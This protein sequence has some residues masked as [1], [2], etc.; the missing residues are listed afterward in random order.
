MEDFYLQSAIVAALTNLSL[1]FVVLLRDPGR[2]VNRAFSAV[3]A[4]CFLWTFGAV[5]GSV[6][7]ISLA[8]AWLPVTALHFIL[9]FVREKHRSSWFWLW[10]SY[11]VSAIL[12]LAVLRRWLAGRAFQIVLILYFAPLIVV[13]FSVLVRRLRQVRSRIERHQ[14]VYVLVGTIVAMLGGTTDLLASLG[15]EIPRLGNLSGLLYVIIMAVAIVRH[16]F[17]DMSVLVGRGIVLFILA[18]LFWSLL[19]VLGAWWSGS[20]YHSFF[21]I[22]VAT[23]LLVIFYEPVK[24]MIE[25]QADKVLQRESYE[26]QRELTAL[27]H[28][29]GRLLPLER[30]VAR[31]AEALY[32]SAKIERFAIYVARRAGDDYRLLKGRGVEGS[33]Y[34][35]IS[36]DRLF[37][38]YLAASKGVVERDA[39][40]RDLEIWAAHPAR[41][42]LIAVS[43]TLAWLKMDVVVPFIYE[44]E[45]YGFMTLAPRDQDGRFSQRERDLLFTVGNQLAIAV[46]N[47]RS[48]EQML[49]TD[50]LAA[51]GEMAA[52][53]A[54]EIRNPLGAIKAA[55]QMLQAGEAYRDDEFMGIIVEEVNRLNRVVSRFL[56][57]ARPLERTFELLDLNTIVSRT[58]ELLRQDLREHG[59]AVE[60]QLAP[61]NP[62]VKGNGDQL[63]Q[64][65]MNLIVNAQ[66][67]MPDGGRLLVTTA[68]IPAKGAREM[69][70]IRVKDSGIGIAREHMD[71]LFDPF[72]TSKPGGTGLGLAIARKIVHAHEGR[73]RVNSRP[74]KGTEFTV[75]LPRADGEGATAAGEGS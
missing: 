8:L 38:K 75:L 37:V 9:T 50:R 61:E 49:Q 64:V 28:D 26:F 56:D 2:R 13:V 69:V 24:S 20:A 66:Q 1:A 70:A 12:S 51:L 3:C 31:V 44:R 22:I 42:E 73:I 54:H 4:T 7:L 17:L 67:A 47:L 19:G 65:L 21:N 32:R 40:E 39:V 15:L 59:I 46:A 16:G 48:H 36:R 11:G 6:Q 10:G 63:K 34:G 45:L 72:F 29:L 14:I 53:L 60:L 57:F 5:I 18:F 30:L 43:R 25:R 55:V 23:V 52:G 33:R 74:G 58:L 41:Q 71:R 27:S 62:Q 68:V 35:V